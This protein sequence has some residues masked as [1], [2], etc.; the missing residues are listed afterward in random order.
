MTGRSPHELAIHGRLWT[1]LAGLKLRGPQGRSSSNLGS[2]TTIWAARP[3]RSTGSSRLPR[4]AAP[5]ERAWFEGYQKPPQ[6]RDRDEEQ[7]EGQPRNGVASDDATHVRLATPD[8]NAPTLPFD[9][10]GSGRPMVLCN[11]RGHHVP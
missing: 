6:V 9:R 7:G 11:P 4:T 10:R 3:V 5:A 8:V 1:Y 2:G